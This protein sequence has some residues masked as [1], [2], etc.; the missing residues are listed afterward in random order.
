MT[1]NSNLTFRDLTLKEAWKLIKI[2]FGCVFA[3]AL[4]FVLLYVLLTLASKSVDTTVGQRTTY[5]WIGY[6]CLSAVLL[7]VV[8]N[9]DEFF[10][11]LAKFFADLANL[12]KAMSKI[13][14]IA[15]AFLLLLFFI[16][17]LI[18]QE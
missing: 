7:L 1:E 2:S 11:S 17:G 5:D 15:F 3:C 16:A 18:S 9:I 4:V 10:S 14:R 13:K 8:F 6:L 12:T